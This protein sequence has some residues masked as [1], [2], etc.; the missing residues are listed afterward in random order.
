MSDQDFMEDSEEVEFI[1]QENELGVAEK[2]LILMIWLLIETIGNGMLFGIIHFDVW[3]G[4]PLKRRIS[5]QVQLRTEIT[6]H[7][8]FLVL[9]PNIS[10]LC[11]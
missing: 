4:D 3:A 10:H 8:G 5:D 9:K 2:V 1:V 7:P 11:S 6:I